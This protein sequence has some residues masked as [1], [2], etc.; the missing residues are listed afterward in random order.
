MGQRG[1][2]AGLLARLL[3]VSARCLAKIGIVRATDFKV[4][5]TETENL[6]VQSVNKTV[7]RYKVLLK[8]IASGDHD[9]ANLDCDTGKS[10][11]ANEYKLSDKTYAR[12]AR[13]NIPKPI[14]SSSVRSYAT[15]F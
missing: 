4:P 5:T 6:Y 1:P 2:Q 7:E 13:S 9:L 10:P 12:L 15:I 8:K 14:S 3:G 11:C